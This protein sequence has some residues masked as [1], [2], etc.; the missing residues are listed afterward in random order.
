MI[1]IIVAFPK[2]EVAKSI[3]NVLVRNGY[4]VQGVAMSGSQA[5]EFLSG[6]ED[7]LIVCGYRFQDM[8]YSEI[9]E[10]MPAGFEML[11]VASKSV[12]QDRE[13]ENIVCLS[14]PVKVHELLS[15]VEM[16]AYGI[17]R[18][19]KQRRNRP[20]ERSAEE[21]ELIR[22]AKGILMERNNLSEDEAH[23]YLLKTSMDSATS[24]SETAQMIL[25][26]MD[27]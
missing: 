4:S 9:A 6:F 5:V 19:R 1:N 23:R 2:P 14:M 26:M 8:M 13:Q 15:T 22:Q 24:L 10:Y 27:Y 11:L 12:W 18:K 16:M 3:R 25:S 21:K 7:G 17:L 20:R